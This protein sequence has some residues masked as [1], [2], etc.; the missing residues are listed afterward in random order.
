GTTLPLRRVILYSNGVA[1]FE[2]RGSVSGKAEITLP[3][4]QS[5]VDD[6]LKSMLVLD[7]GKGQIGAVSYDSSAPTSSR[8][9]EIPFSIAAE[10]GKEDEE[11]GLIKV[12]GQLQGAHVVISSASRSATGSLLNVDEREVKKEADEPTITSRY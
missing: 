6:V 12:L 3:F 2:R 8:L 5:Q 7:L 11:G 10:T 9:A 1:Y 4:K